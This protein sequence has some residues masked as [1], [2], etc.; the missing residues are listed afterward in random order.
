MLTIV[1]IALIM[2]SEQNTANMLVW[3][4]RAGIN[5]CIL[6]KLSLSMPGLWAAELARFMHLS[7]HSGRSFK[8]KVTPVQMRCV[9]LFIGWEYFIPLSDLLH[10]LALNLA[11]ARCPCASFFCIWGPAQ[12]ILCPVS[13]S[14]VNIMFLIALLKWDFLSEWTATFVRM[15]S[16]L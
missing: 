15:F 14:W 6:L 12:G 3:Q 7:S 13:A 5:S 1:C 16:S 11:L 10:S 9:F 4:G 8:T 2:A